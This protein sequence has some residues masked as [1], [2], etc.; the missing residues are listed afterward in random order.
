M[1]LSSLPKEIFARLFQKLFESTLRFNFANLEKIV[2]VK[3][4]N[5]KIL[6]LV[7]NQSNKTRENGD[8]IH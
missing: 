6:I 8:I 1:V 3:I 2:K 5:Q 7:T 4:E